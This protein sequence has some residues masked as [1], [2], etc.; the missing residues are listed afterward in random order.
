MLRM[1]TIDKNGFT[2]IEVVVA[3]LLLALTIGGMLTSFIMGRIA[4][5]QARYNTQAA[6][7][8]QLKVEELSAQLYDD[9]KSQGPIEYAL[10]PGGDLEWGT[11]DDVSGQMW[12]I[13][14]DRRDLDGDGDKS[15]E[16]IDVDGDGLNDPCKPVRVNVIWP[17]LTFSGEQNRLLSFETLIAKR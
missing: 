11:D 7:A 8:I 10:D 6:N 14:E 15:E 13:V 9:V 12:I 16:E 3:V 1:K 5:Y 4:T 17:C 2:L